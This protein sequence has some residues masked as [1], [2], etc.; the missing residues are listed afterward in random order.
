MKNSYTKH[1]VEREGMKIILEI[2]PKNVRDEI[3]KEELKSIM[4]S[5]LK[6]Q[7]QKMS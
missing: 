4:Y 7:L 5:T 3:I 1:E 2:P 6:E